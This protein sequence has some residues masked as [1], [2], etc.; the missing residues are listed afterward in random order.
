MI[1]AADTYLKILK[2]FRMV[3]PIGTKNVGTTTFPL[4]LFNGRIK[5]SNRA[6]NCSIGTAKL[7]SH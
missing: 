4:L 6:V 2:T 7:D 3:R 1:K 5:Y